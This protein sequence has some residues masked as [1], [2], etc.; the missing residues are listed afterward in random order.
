[1][2]NTYSLNKL[3]NRFIGD[4]MDNWW[5]VASYFFDANYLTKKSFVNLFQFANEYRF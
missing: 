1:M 5:M 4:D 3:E 2:R